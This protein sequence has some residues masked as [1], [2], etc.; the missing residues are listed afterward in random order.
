MAIHGM[1]RLVGR[2]WCNLRSGKDI[3]WAP[4]WTGDQHQPKTLLVYFFN[5]DL[6]WFFSN[7]CLILAIQIDKYTLIRFEKRKRHSMSNFYFQSPLNLCKPHINL[8]VNIPWYC[9]SNC[10]TYSCLGSYQTNSN[11]NRIVFNLNLKS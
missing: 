5:F 4:G 2:H 3:Q 7:I 10:S 11:M 8:G 6:F 1:V 9:T